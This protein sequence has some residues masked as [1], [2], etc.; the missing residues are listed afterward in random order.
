[1]KTLRKV[2]IEGFK[3]IERAELELGDL[4]VVIGANGSGK[5]NL[6]GAFRLLERVLSGRLQQFVANNPPRPA[7]A[8][9]AQDHTCVVA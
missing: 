1:M 2:K 6:L 5:S 7:L 9:R 4:N 8:S 3:S